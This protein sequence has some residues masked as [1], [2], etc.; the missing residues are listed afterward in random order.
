MGI[1][2]QR[3]KCCDG[4]LV[5]RFCR[6]CAMAINTP[7]TSI[8]ATSYPELLQQY[9]KLQSDHQQLQTN[10]DTLYLEQQRLQLQLL[11]FRKMLFGSSHERFI[12][13]K[14]LPE[15][16]ALFTV[17]AI[18]EIVSIGTSTITYEKKKTQL[19]PIQR[20]RNPLPEHLRRQQIVI[21][22]AHIDKAKAQK[23]GEDV[24]EILAYQPCELYVKR[25]VRPKYSDIA[26]RCIVQAPAPVRPIEKSNA[27]STLLAQMIIDKF[28]DHLP[29]HR[30]INR[31]ARLGVTMSDSTVSDQVG[32]VGNLIEPLYN[33]HL[34][35]T[36]ASNYLHVDE[37]V[38][39]VLDSEKKNA[40]HQGYYW[41]YQSAAAK[42][43]LYDY[44]PGRG[45]HG[46]QIMLKGF[47]GYIQTDGYSV[48]DYFDDD[49]DITQICCMAHARRKFSEAL[50]NDKQ[51]AS[52]ALAQMQQLYAFERYITD[53]K[54]TGSQ[55]WQYRKD[56]AVPLL[57]ELGQWM[58]QVLE[59][60]S[61]ISGGFKEALTYSINRWD[62]LSLY[63][64]T[65]FL[66]IDNNAVENSIR[67]IVI[68]RKNYLFAGSH[69]A[70][71][72]A[73]MFYSLL[74]TCKNY[75]VN[76]YNWL[77]DVLN[78]IASH[79][80]NRIGE[81]LPQYWKNNSAV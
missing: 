58:Q 35:E 64:S 27:D 34:K 65:D 41:V 68:G 12:S 24:T 74:A 44:Q 30:Q 59:E 69:D 17:P 25:I 51:R 46:P 7:D 3:N 47:K 55:K 52:Y 75:H 71:R 19:Q 53:N 28:M 22:P 56:N 67:P 11:K 1:N 37:T 32:S 33:A 54:L 50:H 13:S 70:A 79:P 6:C 36:L 18:A 72:R 77:V 14:E 73:G 20:G 9:E 29:M 16:G 10:Y 60:K 21:E 45:R 31:Y 23:I 78:R 4:R 8:I 38:I 62:K 61:L 76:P 15:Q 49:P 26:L 43:T 81:L 42:L 80:I 66:H 5:H 57:K 39:K 2:K 48:Y 40:T 63:A